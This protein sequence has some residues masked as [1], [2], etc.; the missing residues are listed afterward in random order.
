[1]CGATGNCALWVFDWQTGDLILSADGWGFKVEP[2]LHHGR[3]D[4]VTRANMSAFGGV[5]DLYEFDGHVYQQVRE[6]NEIY[7]NGLPPS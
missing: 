7:T 4:I 6:T 1:V 3:Y 2:T 5:R